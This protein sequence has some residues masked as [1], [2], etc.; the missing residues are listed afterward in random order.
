MLYCAAP[1]RVHE[2]NITDRIEVRSYVRISLLTSAWHLLLLKTNFCRILVMW[3]IVEE[4]PSKR[5]L[6]DCFDIVAT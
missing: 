6:T 1:R 5:I 4:A 2:F 3:I